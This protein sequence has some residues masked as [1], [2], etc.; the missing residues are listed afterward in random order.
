M[1]TESALAFHQ[2]SFAH[3]HRGRALPV[4]RDI[5]IDF[6]Q[7]SRTTILGPSGGGKST[8]LELASGILRPDTGSIHLGRVDL[9]EAAD[10][11][12][13]EL[14][15][16]KIGFVRQDFDLLADFTALENA[17][18]GLRLR[19]IPKPEAQDRA[20][21]ALERLG[22][23]DR[24]GHRPKQLSGGE[25]QRVALARVLVCEPEVILA[26]EP[27][28]SL[29]ADLRD[30]ALHW[31]FSIAQDATLIVVTHDQA[32]AD[33][34]GERQFSL[35]QGRLRPVRAEPEPSDQDG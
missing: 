25:Q 30:E 1:T 14:R 24:V 35:R 16:A 34:V 4:L 2:V 28:G 13:A 19:K 10:D 33:Q 6:P 9:S 20:S 12:R 26:D 29:D 21:E 3:H 18:L 23:A 5:S 17:A 22:L 31:L 27:T 15:L 8:L 7:R 32:V 11:R